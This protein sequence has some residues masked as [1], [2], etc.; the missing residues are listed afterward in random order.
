MG[1]SH[2]P[3]GF[4]VSGCENTKALSTS[5]WT[6]R[7]WLHDTRQASR[8]TCQQIGSR[9]AR[10][11]SQVTSRMHGLA[12]CNRRI[13]VCQGLPARPPWTKSCQAIRPRTK[14]GSASTVERKSPCLHDLD[15]D[16][17][18]DQ[19]RNTLCIVAFLRNGTFSPVSRPQDVDWVP[20]T[21]SAGRDALHPDNNCSGGC[22]GRG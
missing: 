10:G 6:D 22:V 21:T 5:R 15:S 16:M 18:P 8:L 12:N 20:C 4:R 3:L 19:S 11:V 13:I 7:W 9:R 17:P 1:W 2:R 14:R